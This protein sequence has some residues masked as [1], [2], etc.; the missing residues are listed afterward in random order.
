MKSHHRKH[1]AAGGGMESPA[2]GDREYE[3]DLKEKNQRYT[4]QSKVNDEAEER[5][6]GGRTK[7]H[8]GKVHGMH[9]MHHAGRKPRKAGGRTGS[10]MNPLS[11]AH[12]GTPPKGHKDVEID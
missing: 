6:H 2:A 4:Y 12:H 7:K 1:K 9:A 8:V 3:Q 10:N 11:S 5:K